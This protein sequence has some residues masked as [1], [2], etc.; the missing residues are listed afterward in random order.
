MSQSRV[1]LLPQCYVSRLH[2]LRPGQTGVSNQGMDPR[3]LWI[4]YASQ[5]CDSDADSTLRA[6][7]ALYE[8][9]GL[10]RRLAHL[11]GVYFISMTI[12]NSG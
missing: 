7:P 4:R 12:D 2:A 3:L 6:V 1:S 5:P 10:A 9:G 8:T 11:T